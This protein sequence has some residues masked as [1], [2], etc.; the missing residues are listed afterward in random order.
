MI[1]AMDEIDKKILQLLQAD[2]SISVR[3]IA[4]EVGLT[5]TPCW[6]RIQALE[7]SG[8]ISQRVAIVDPQ[9]VNLALTAIVL[10]RTNEHNAEWTDRFLSTIERFD[11]VVEAYRTSGEL[12]YLLKVMVA[13]M[14][15][16]DQFYLRLI[17]YIDLYDVRSTFVMEKM[18][19]TT[20]LPLSYA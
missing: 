19:Q 13:D 7:N 10:I 8:I 20:A 2:A 1:A 14:D 15:A 17:E 12:D 18:K 16:Y 9:S 6:R 3:E 11:E 4:D 5:S